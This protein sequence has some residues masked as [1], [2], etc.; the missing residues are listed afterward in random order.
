MATSSSP[1]DALGRLITLSGHIQSSVSTATVAS[2]EF[3]E[4]VLEH[5]DAV[6]D[7]L[8]DVCRWHE[9]V[10]HQLNHGAQRRRTMLQHNAQTQDLFGDGPFGDAAAP[11]GG[12]NNI[13]IRSVSAAT[14]RVP[15]SGVPTPSH[16]T[17]QPHVTTTT[18]TM[19]RSRVLVMREQ[20]DATTTDDWEF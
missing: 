13:T 2:T 17:L 9:Q 19:T 10:K 16:S 15:S 14:G 8:H 1:L 20:L 7:V 18:T 5:L 4:E 12:G 6:T 3:M 11:G